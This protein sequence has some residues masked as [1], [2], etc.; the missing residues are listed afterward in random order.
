MIKTSLSVAADQSAAKAIC[1]RSSG[2]S[3]APLELEDDPIALQYRKT[4]GMDHAHLANYRGTNYYQWY[5][6]CPDG[7]HY[8]RGPILEL[9]EEGETNE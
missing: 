2:T 7:F 4:G 5:G 6:R 1:A 3:G 9:L 8:P